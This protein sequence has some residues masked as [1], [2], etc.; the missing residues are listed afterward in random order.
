M[1]NTLFD[2]VFKKLRMLSYRSQIALLICLD[3]HFLLRFV[4]PAIKGVILRG[5]FL[6]IRF[7]KVKTR[8]LGGFSKLSEI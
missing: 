2:I 3:P 5:I 8:S 1:D 7:G 6:S 4:E